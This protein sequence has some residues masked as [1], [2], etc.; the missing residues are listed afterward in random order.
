MRAHP[1]AKLGLRLHHITKKHYSRVQD[2]SVEFASSFG[3][4][5]LT[6][7]KRKN[8]NGKTY[9]GPSEVKPVH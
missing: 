7:L 1:D 8:E 3:H 4:Y 2:Q 9:P 5:H 6:L